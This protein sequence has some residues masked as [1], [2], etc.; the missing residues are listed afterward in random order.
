MF[1]LK[2]TGMNVQLILNIGTACELHSEA[3][4]KNK[5]CAKKMWAFV[6]CMANPT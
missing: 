1:T 5:N 6:T 4:I 2:F 3:I